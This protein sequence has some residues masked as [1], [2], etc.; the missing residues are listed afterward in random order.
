MLKE[1][2]EELKGV[3]NTIKAPSGLGKNVEEKI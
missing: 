2:V 1:A 3:L